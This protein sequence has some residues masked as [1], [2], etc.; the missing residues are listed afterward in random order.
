MNR[1]AGL[2]V[3]NPDGVL[4]ASAGRD[5]NLAAAEVINS[6]VGGKT[7]MEAGRD[8]NIGTIKETENAYAASSRKNWWRQ[9]KTQEVGSVIQTNGDLTLTAN[10]N[11]T[12]R[13]ATVTSDNGALTAVAGNDLTIESGDCYLGHGVLSQEQEERYL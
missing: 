10:R 4:V 6:G 1:V 3:S 2:Y 11:I 8:L 12:A 7:V 9:D 5:I 13:A